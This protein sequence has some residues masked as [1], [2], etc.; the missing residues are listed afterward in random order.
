VRQGLD[1][2][3]PPSCVAEVLGTH[4]DRIKQ[5]LADHIFDRPHNGAWMRVAPGT[6]SPAPC[7]TSRAS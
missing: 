6:R 4:P 1:G 3:D 5:E 7:R 2:D